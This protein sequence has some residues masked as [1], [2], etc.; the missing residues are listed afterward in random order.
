MCEAARLKRGKGPL[1]FPLEPVHAKRS[2]PIRRRRTTRIETP[3]PKPVIESCRIAHRDCI[4][5]GRVN[6][7]TEPEP[8]AVAPATVEV[9]AKFTPPVEVS[10]EATAALRE[11]IPPIEISP[12]V[13]MIGEGTA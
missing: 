8:W 9:A 10:G 4:F 6:A 2:I 7:H 3:D 1:S 5:V 12:L 13:A 11:L